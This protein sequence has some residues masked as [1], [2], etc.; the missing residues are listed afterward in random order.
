MNDTKFASELRDLIHRESM[1]AASGTPDHILARYMIACLEAF[2][3]A[4]CER[5]QFHNPTTR[6]DTEGET[7]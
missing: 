5:S 4:T 2:N 1:E 3:Q 6:E 7:Q